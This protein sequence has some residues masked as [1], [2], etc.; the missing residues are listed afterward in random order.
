MLT[1]LL[2]LLL[3]ACIVGGFTIIIRTGIMVIGVF[4]LAIILIPLLWILHPWFEIVVVILLAMIVY[5]N[6]V[7]MQRTRR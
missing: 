5:Q 1:A 3:A 6:L 4:M 2:L 7:K